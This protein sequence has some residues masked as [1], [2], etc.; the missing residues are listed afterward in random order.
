MDLKFLIIFIFIGASVIAGGIALFLLRRRRT[1]SSF[2]KRIHCLGITLML[3]ISVVIAYASQEQIKR[4]AGDRESL[5]E[6]IIIPIRSV[7]ELYPAAFNLSDV[8]ES[9]MLELIDLLIGDGEITVATLEEGTIKL[10]TFL[11]QMAYSPNGF[12]IPDY[13]QLPED[14]ISTELN[15]VQ[16][17]EGCLAQMRRLV[18]MLRP[19]LSYR[20]QDPSTR[21]NL[22]E[23]THYMAICSKDAL[24]WGCKDGSNVISNEMIWLLD[25][26]AFVGIIN[27]YIYQDHNPAMLLDIY[28][29]QSQLFDYLAYIADTKE[30][31][32]NMNFISLI[33]TTCAFEELQNQGF[34]AAK[35][36]YSKSLWD[37]HLDILYRVSLDVDSTDQEEFFK[38]M[39]EVENSLQNAA[40][41]K[42]EVD[43]IKYKLEKYEL[44]VIW[45]DR[46][47]NKNENEEAPS[48]QFGYGEE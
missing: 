47:V 30:L 40:L 16:T 8:D 10:H 22:A 45:R 31:K 27:E 9:V 38:L 42:A 18:E 21:Q 41:S 34:E 37:F 39:N 26:F 32:L 24:Y 15:D 36:L 4:K 2:I 7:K 44:Y 11:E 33:C 19:L 20:H 3:F 5:P 23:L 14:E 29:R 17:V 35:S 46:N 48:P 43:Y 12:P 28:Y 6:P 25:E 13:L 1:L